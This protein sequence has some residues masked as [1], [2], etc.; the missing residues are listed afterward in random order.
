MGMGWHDVYVRGENCLL[1]G[2]EVLEGTEVLL[3]CETRHGGVV[4]N[5]ARG[6]LKHPEELLFAGVR[7]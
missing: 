4:R 5:L 3:A 6:V 7:R 1:R 2:D